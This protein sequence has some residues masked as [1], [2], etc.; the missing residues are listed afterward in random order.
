MNLEE[1]KEII[2][3]TPPEF[4]ISQPRVLYFEAKAFLDGYEQ[5]I[6]DA[7]KALSKEGIT[8]LC[9]S[10]LRLLDEVKK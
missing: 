5:G 3:N 2:K 4:N 8:H 9:L 7:D 10:V 1:A 6:R